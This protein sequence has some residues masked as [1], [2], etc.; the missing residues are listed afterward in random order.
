VLVPERLPIAETVRARDALTDGGLRVGAVV[1]NRVFPDG[2]HPFLA[3][4]AVQQTHW[5]TEI[6]DVLGAHPRVRLPHLARDPGRDDL[7][8]LADRLADAGW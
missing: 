8:A 2:D 4:R 3:A 1:V 7:D 5:L 6:D